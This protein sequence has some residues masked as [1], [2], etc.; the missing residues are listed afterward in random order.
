[1]ISTAFRQLAEAVPALASLELK[2]CPTQPT[3]GH[4]NVFAP[5][6]HRCGQDGSRTGR[7]SIVGKH[8]CISHVLYRLW[9][10]QLGGD[11]SGE[12]AWHLSIRSIIAALRSSRH[13][14]RR[15]ERCPLA[16][17]SKCAI[18]GAS[19]AG[20]RRPPG[21]C[22]LSTLAAQQRPAVSIAKVASDTTCRPRRLFHRRFR[23]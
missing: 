21:A 15:L 20:A 9:W 18:R 2:A 23:M 8:H 4:G 22:S 10:R 13:S 7:P 12:T 3:A 11:D 1:M 5:R 19:D 14:R 6:D 16:R 17:S